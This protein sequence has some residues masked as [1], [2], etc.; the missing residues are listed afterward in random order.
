MSQRI[1]PFKKKGLR[2]FGGLLGAQ[3]MQHSRGRVSVYGRRPDPQQQT[4]S[5][6]SF[7][8]HRWFPD[9]ETKISMV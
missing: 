1:N 4:E 6:N 8:Q 9:L 5:K 3:L 2:C 7:V